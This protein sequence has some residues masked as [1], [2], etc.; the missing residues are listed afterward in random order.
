MTDFMEKFNEMSNKARMRIFFNQRATYIEQHS[1]VLIF[2][3]R[4]MKLFK[5]KRFIKINPSL[6][7]KTKWVQFSLN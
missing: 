2:E 6:L 7:L 3:V 5:I 4:D 1:I